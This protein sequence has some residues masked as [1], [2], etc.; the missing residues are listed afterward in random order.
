MPVAL[1]R[2]TRTVALTAAL[3]LG[4]AACGSSDSSNSSSTSN[5]SSASTSGAAAQATGPVTV[6]DAQGRSV[7]VAANPG[8]VV[9]LDWSV[10]RSLTQLGVPIAALPKASG[11][12]PAD[13]AA[14]KSVKTV[15]T[16]FEPDYEAIAE[17]EPDL[18]IIGGRS[19]NAKVLKE[20]TKISPNVIDMSVREDDATKHLSAV[21]DQ[22]KTLA[23]IWGK[24]SQADTHL[25]SMNK[26]IGDVRTKATNAGGT[27]MFVQVSGSK[28]GAYGPGSRF[29]TV[30]TDFGFKPVNAP[31]KSDG[32][33]GDE[34]NQEFFLKYNPSRVLVLDR[35]RTIGESAKPALDVLNSGLVNKTDA[36]KNKKISTVDGFSWYLA[37]DT[38]L[39]YIAA[40]NDLAKVL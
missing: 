28:V 26:A 33:H 38:P 9:V 21:S 8:K 2:P 32:G 13:M 20:M 36:A 31:L 7:K 1:A 34:I 25:A 30:W 37:T 16:L 29:G 24:S 15:G 19:G 40:A 22:Y 5:G 14:L 18:I 35:S 12:L 27:T 6:K 17:L 4:L 39:S 3:A 23:S 11:E 10:A